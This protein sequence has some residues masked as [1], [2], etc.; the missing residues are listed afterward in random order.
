MF[1]LVITDSD[2]WTLSIHGPMSDD[3]TWTVRVAAAQRQGRSV[4]CSTPA[5]ED[6]ETAIVDDMIARGFTQVTAVP[7]TAKLS[8]L[9]VRTIPIRML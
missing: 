8:P 5:P 6:A 7:L 2:H 3:K 1:L 9:L 4:R